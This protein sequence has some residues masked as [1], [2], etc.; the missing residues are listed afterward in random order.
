MNQQPISNRL[1]ALD[2]LRGLIMILMAVDHAG[3]MVMRLHVSEHWGIALPEHASFTSFFTRFITHLCAP[4]FAFLMGTG[5]SLFAQSRI[6][7]GWE[8]KRIV[9]YF[10]TRG[11][12]IILIHQLIENPAWVLSFVTVESMSSLGP[13]APGTAAGGQPFI[14]L[15]VLYSLGGSMIVGSLLWRLSAP[16]QA[17]LGVACLLATQLVVP[18]AASA[19]EV[20]SVPMRLLWFSGQTTPWLVL[21]PLIPWLGICLLGMAFGKCHARRPNGLTQIAPLLGLCL[22]VLFFI[23]RAVN[24]FGNIHPQSGQGIMAYLSLTKYPPSLV[25]VTLT[26]GIDLLILGMLS[27]FASGAWAK[28]LLV[29]GRA[30]LFFYLAHLWLYS[31]IGAFFPKGTS[32]PLM[33]FIWLLGVLLL[34]PASAWYGRFK[35]GKPADSIWRLL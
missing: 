29:F 26:L 31:L 13:G 8:A 24:G 27:R 5:M 28:P 12:L 15:T 11:G 25:F 17:G 1:D 14:I 4:G 19:Q 16:I 30:P 23:L 18:D 21:Y 32:Y 7:A 34:Y 22:L 20:F 2:H 10:A 33:Y 35:R 9:R 6:A 3:A